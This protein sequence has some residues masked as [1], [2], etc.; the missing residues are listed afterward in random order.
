M[1]RLARICAV[2]RSAVNSYNYPTQ[3]TKY[4]IAGFH[5]AQ[6]PSTDSSPPPPTK[7]LDPPNAKHFGET[8]T[9]LQSPSKPLHSAARNHSN[10]GVL[11]QNGILGYQSYFLGYWDIASVKMGYCFHRN[12]NISLLKMGYW[13]ICHLKLG[14]SGYRDPP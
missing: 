10:R 1:C 11:A 6:K 8:N 7:S 4:G 12:L 5:T 9:G 2:H 3:G 13:D 14:Y